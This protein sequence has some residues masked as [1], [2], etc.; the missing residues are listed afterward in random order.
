METVLANH[1][2]P[3]AEITYSIDT[4]AGLEVSPIAFK[5]R[6]DSLVHFG[7]VT[8]EGV[9]RY[10]EYVARRELKIKPGNV[11]RFEDVVQSQKRLFESGYFSTL[12]LNRAEDGSDRL[13]PNFILKVRERKTKYVTFKMGAG[14]SL[15]RDLV[16]ALSNNFGKRNL[17]G[18]RRIDLLSDYSFSVGQDSR[19]ITHRYRLR[20]TEPWFLGIR[21]PLILTGEVEPK[22]RDDV[23]D[24]KIG[25]WAVSAATTKNFGLEVKTTFGFQYESVNIS[26]V[27]PDDEA[28]IRRDEGLSVRRKIL[29]NLQARQPRQY[30][31][32]SQGFIDG[33]IVR[34]LR[35]FPRRGRQ[36][37]IKY[38]PVGRVISP[39]G[40]GGFP[41]LASVVDGRII[42]GIPTISRSMTA[43]GLGGAN[44]VRGFREKYLGPLYDD[45]TPK[46]SKY[47]VLF[48]QEFRW[49]TIQIFNALPFLKDLFRTLPLWQSV[50]FDV[51]NGFE[52]F[53]AIRL[54]GLALSYGTGIQIQSPA[55]P[56][57]IDYARVIKTERFEADDRF[58]FHHPLRLLKQ[59]LFKQLNSPY[60][61]YCY[62][63][64]KPEIILCRKKYWWLSPAGSI[65]PSPPCF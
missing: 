33:N 12:Q 25:T 50:F 53:E 29:F 39:S 61:A 10:P 18:S 34:I 14:Q 54:D 58:H 21:M 7:E 48:N 36:F 1:G 49:K 59:D 47:F 24:Y 55:G 45:G 40:R 63:R 37:S 41:P 60:I 35:R 27:S 22:L 6:S 16:W 32:P 15:D 8:V 42:S 38:K 26:G 23:Q 56:I 3:Y 20:Y 31:Y 19:L 13:N 43:F 64:L 17:F 5:I 44:S 9:D 46:G 62:K 51:G 2:Y 11:Y 28:D 52:T 65:P 4:A 30:I 57:R